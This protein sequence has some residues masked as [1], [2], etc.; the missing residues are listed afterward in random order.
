MA[1]VVASTTCLLT[2]LITSESVS[3]LLKHYYLQQHGCHRIENVENNYFER[4]CFVLASEAL[5]GRKYGG[6]DMGVLAAQVEAELEKLTEE[7]E[8]S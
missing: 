3:R 5:A 6:G 2:R 4:L 1:V 7:Q 8:R